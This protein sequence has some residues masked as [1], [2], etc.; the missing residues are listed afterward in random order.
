MQDTIPVLKRLMGAYNRSFDQYFENNET[1]TREIL[2]TDQEFFYLSFSFM[3]GAWDGRA[4][5][6]KERTVYSPLIQLVSYVRRLGSP[7]FKYGA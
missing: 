2:F 4:G 7:A 6:V 5:E 1:D 3:D